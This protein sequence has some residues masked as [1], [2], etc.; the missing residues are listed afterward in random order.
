MPGFHFDCPADGAL[1]EL[2]SGDVAIVPGHPDESALLARISSPDPE[3]R[4]PPE[5]EPLKPEEIAA[6]RNWIIQNAT[7]PSDESPDRHCR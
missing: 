2:D 7:A 1:A 4:M 3:V 5:G 6:L